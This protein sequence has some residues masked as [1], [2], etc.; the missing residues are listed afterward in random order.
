MKGKEAHDARIVAAMLA[1]R[2][3]NLLTF[4]MGDF[5]RYTQIT[6]VDLRDV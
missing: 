2:V 1:H 4:N 5:K 6:S 3:S